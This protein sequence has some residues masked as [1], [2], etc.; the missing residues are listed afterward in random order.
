MNFLANENFPKP[1]IS[2]LQEKGF[3]VSCIAGKHSGISEEEVIRMARDT[4]RII[5]TFGKDYGQIN[6]RFGH[7]DPPAIVYF[8]SKG[9]GPES[10]SVML[11]QALEQGIDLAQSF[12]IIDSDIIRQRKYKTT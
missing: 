10:A 8:K 6:F 1:S 5:L 3:D 2:A 9:G 7:P 4:D 12:T 11:L